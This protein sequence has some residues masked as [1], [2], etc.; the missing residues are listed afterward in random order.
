MHSVKSRDHFRYY[1]VR[2]SRYV[3]GHMLDFRKGQLETSM[4][5]STEPDTGTAQLPVKLYTAGDST[6]PV[7]E[8][9]LVPPEPE[10]A[11]SAG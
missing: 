6:A 3:V 1:I 8:T 2:G 5:G 11:T 7:D 4:N 10:P 9:L